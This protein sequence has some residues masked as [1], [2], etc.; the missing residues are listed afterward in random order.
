MVKENEVR[1]KIH[2]ILIDFFEVDNTLLVQ[3]KPLD[4]LQAD[5]KILGYLLFLEQLIHKEFGV[6]IPLLENISADIHTPE[7]IVQLTLSALK[8]KKLLHNH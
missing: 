1:S 6:K 7:D 8:S 5:F 3:K 2:R 4:A